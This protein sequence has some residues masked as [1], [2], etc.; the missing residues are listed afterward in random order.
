MRKF[1]VALI[2]GLL[3]SAG[4][5]GAP[6]PKAAAASPQLKVVLVVG[7]VEGTTS[8]YRAD[9]DAAA[10]EFLKFTSNVVKV[11]SPNATWA[12]VQAAAV[13]RGRPVTEIADAWAPPLR[14]VAEPRPGQGGADLRRRYHRLAR[15]EELDG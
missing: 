15:L 7:A 13:L 3:V 5:I 6:V 11:Y 1:A 10:T 4:G 9:A 8:S 14:L 2:V 12:A